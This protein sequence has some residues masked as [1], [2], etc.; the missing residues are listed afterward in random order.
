MP[1]SSDDEP[2]LTYINVAIALSFIVV[3]SPFLQRH[4]VDGSYIFCCAWIGN[5][6]ICSCCFG[7]MFNS[8]IFDGILH[9]FL[10]SIPLG[11]F[12]LGEVFLF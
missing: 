12:T 4:V 3:D 5:R 7:T 1:S 9:R 8:V 10:V 2:E 11:C 6:E